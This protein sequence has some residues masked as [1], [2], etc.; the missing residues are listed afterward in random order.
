MLIA[1]KKYAIK[2][3]VEY[4]TVEMEGLVKNKI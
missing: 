1:Y 2:C 4:Y 3:V